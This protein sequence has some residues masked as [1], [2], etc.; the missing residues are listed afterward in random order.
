M[1]QNVNFKAA[2]Y[3][4]LV[5]ALT[6][7]I[8]NYWLCEKQ[9]SVS[10]IYNSLSKSI[11]VILIIIFLFNK[12]LWKYRIFKKWLVLI[13]NLNGKWKGSI[14]SNWVNSE[15]KEKIASIET[16]LSISQSL[17][18]INCAMESSE[19]KSNSIT[20]NFIIDEDNQILKLSYVYMSEPNQNARSR[21][22]IHY[23]TII[24]DIL[25]SENNKIE[26]KGNYWTDRETTGTIN[27]IKF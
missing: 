25:K 11:T 14:Y 10:Y 27:L 13:P 8:I 17:F 24:F 23:G 18:H 19:M 2:L 4:I 5:I 22:Q 3:I 1:R 26:L 20:A 16:T 15:T 6:V 7:F 21:S 12:Y 9:F